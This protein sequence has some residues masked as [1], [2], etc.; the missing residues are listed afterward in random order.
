MRRGKARDCVFVHVSWTVMEARF[1]LGGVFDPPF[2]TVRP[3][4]TGVVPLVK[5]WDRDWTDARGITTAATTGGGG[6]RVVR[7]VTAALA[8]DGRE[9]SSCT[10][11][12]AAGTTLSDLLCP[13]TGYS[14][15]SNE[16]HNTAP[17]ARGSTRDLTASGGDT[18]AV[19]SSCC[20]GSTD[21]TSTTT[22]SETARELCKAVS[23]SLG[24]AVDP[25]AHHDGDR[26]LDLFGV[27]R[28]KEEEEEEEGVHARSDGRN[29]RSSSSSASASGGGA[30]VGREGR[31][32][33]VHGDSNKLLEMFKSGG[34]EDMMMMMMQMDNS[35]A[36]LQ[37]AMI[38]EN[39]E[40][41]PGVAS[42]MGS[43]SASAAAGSS[44]SSGSCQFQQ[45]E[46]HEQHD[47]QVNFEPALSVHGRYCDDYYYYYWPRYNN[48]RVK[49]EAV[50]PPVTRYGHGTAQYGN[51]ACTA[52]AAALDAPLICSPYEYDYSERMAPGPGPGPGSALSAA[53]EPWYQQTGEV[54]PRVS[55]PTA[56]CMKN[57]VGSWLDVSTM[58]DVR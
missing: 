39:S 16:N 57:E 24:L 50:P 35:R 3:N 15:N 30:I 51:P 20:S 17:R 25:H 58:Q 32:P 34:E 52:S 41:G 56:T 31:A 42:L 46:Q 33:H 28:R 23:V 6:G 18:S 2:R 12:R 37:A 47:P 22:I 11:A 27:R 5:M 54:L 38:T 10:E 14:N 53:H 55:Y 44:S 36:H 40:F 4:G 13:E 9:N 48:V 49:S 26:S 19:P 29:R 21:T 1:G 45:H 7:S 8:R 43:K